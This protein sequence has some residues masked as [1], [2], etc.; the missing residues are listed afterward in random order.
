MGAVNNML[1][2]C[3]F[4]VLFAVIISSLSGFFPAGIVAVMGSGVLEISTGVFNASSCSSVLMRLILTSA[5]I[6][7][8]GLSVHFQVMGIVSKTDLRTTQYFIGKL[9]QAVIAAAYTAVALCVV[10]LDVSAV[11]Y[12]MYPIHA[13][14]LIDFAAAV[15]LVGALYGECGVYYSSAVA[16]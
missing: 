15:K 9:L 2:V 3:G 1:L 8:A 12:Y 5:I 16:V 13:Y 10:P 11:S 14:E 7:F 6:G 4:T